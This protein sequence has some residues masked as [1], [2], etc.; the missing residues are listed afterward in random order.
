MVRVGD[1]LFLEGAKADIQ[2]IANDMG[3]IDVAKPSA[4]AYRRGRTPIAIAV[5][6]GLVLLRRLG[7]RQ[8]F[9]FLS[10]PLP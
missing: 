6:V 8:S 1:K 3:L 5:V 4:Q 9:Y 2:R 10:S 7:W